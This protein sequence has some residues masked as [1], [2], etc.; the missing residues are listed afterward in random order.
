M[1]ADDWSTIAEPAHKRME[2]EL[3]A[4]WQPIVDAASGESTSLAQAA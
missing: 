3:G 4:D 2:Q 1:V